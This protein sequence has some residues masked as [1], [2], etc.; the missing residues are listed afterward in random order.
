MKK[1]LIAGAVAGAALL[2]MAAP[3]MAAKL[4]KVEICHVIDSFDIPAPNPWT[5][6]VG[7]WIN[8]NENSLPGH[9]GHGDFLWT[10]GIEGTGVKNDIDYG[11]VIFGLTWRQ[12]AENNGLDTT[13]AE[14]AGFVLDL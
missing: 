12:I 1:K 6:V 14:C 5:T 9:L 10:D 3:L 2:I 13:D 7:R 4:P 8:V 11:P